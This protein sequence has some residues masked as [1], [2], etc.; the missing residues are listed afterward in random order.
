MW[1]GLCEISLNS[2]NTYL[3]AHAIAPTHVSP[4]SQT[5][6]TLFLILYSHIQSNKNSQ[7]QNH[8]APGNSTGRHKR[9][10]VNRPRYLQTLKYMFMG[11]CHI[12]NTCIACQQSITFAGR[13]K[14]ANV[15]ARGVW[16][17]GALCSFWCATSSIQG[18]DDVAK[19]GE[20]TRC[21][22]P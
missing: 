20:N 7:K 4:V 14:C 17:I 13:A 9:K 21:Q 18:S 12:T 19:T 8:D 10:S 3:W 15:G 1:T 16:R 2:K 22:T 6:S 5:F 11:I